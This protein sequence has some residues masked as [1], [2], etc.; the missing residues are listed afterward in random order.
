[1]IKTKLLGKHK[2]GCLS[3]KNYNTRI[4]DT[5]WA[6]LKKAVWL[7]KSGGKRGRFHKYR[8]WIV[9]CNDSDCDARILVKEDDILNQISR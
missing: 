5:P 4:W 7:D 3:L 9:I 1:M 8:W 6:Y 2:K